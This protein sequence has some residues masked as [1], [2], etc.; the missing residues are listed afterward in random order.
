MGEVGGAVGGGRALVEDE[1]GLVPGIFQA[2]LEDP[3]FFPEP[4]DLPLPLRR[5]LLYFARLKGHSFP[6]FPERNG[7]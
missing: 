1:L 4:E 5:V 2:P 3:V 6:P 7:K